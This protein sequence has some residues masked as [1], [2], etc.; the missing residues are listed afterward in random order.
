MRRAIRMY[1]WYFFWNSIAYTLVISLKK[2]MNYKSGQL[3]KLHVALTVVA[4]LSIVSLLV[5][6]IG[7]AIV[8]R[9]D[10]P[11]GFHCIVF[12]VLIF[13]VA[14]LVDVCMLRLI[15]NF[16]SDLCMNS[17]DRLLLAGL[18]Q[19]IPIGILKDPQ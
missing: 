5:Y 12:L 7:T 15:A 9:I 11:F 4:M 6:R 2:V 10:R 17:L 14:M 3:G 16:M 8:V 19:I 18:C 13:A 1:I